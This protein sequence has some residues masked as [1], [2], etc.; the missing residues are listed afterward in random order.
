MMNGAASCR[1]ERVLVL[2]RFTQIA[3][4]QTHR[5]LKI[6]DVVRPHGIFSVGMLEQVLGRDDHRD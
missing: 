3:T 2:S 1:I 4:K 5:L 6:V